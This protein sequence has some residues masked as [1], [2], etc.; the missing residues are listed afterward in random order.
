[1]NCQIPTQGNSIYPL[2]IDIDL[3]CQI[4]AQITKTDIPTAVANMQELINEHSLLF[5]EMENLDKHAFILDPASPRREH[6]HRRLALGHHCSLH[7]DITNLKN[8]RSEPPVMQLYGA[9]S[10]IATWRD[11]LNRNLSSW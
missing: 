10:K 3:P 8:P 2:K 6:T 4:P 9:E 7:I 5:D 1:M 11:A